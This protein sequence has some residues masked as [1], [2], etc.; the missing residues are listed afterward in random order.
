M[1]DGSLSHSAAKNEPLIVGQ[2]AIALFISI[3]VAKM[4]YRLL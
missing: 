4:Q 2:L 3:L 1:G